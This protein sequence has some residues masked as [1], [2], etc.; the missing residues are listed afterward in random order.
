[1]VIDLLLIYQKKNEIVER[2]K[3]E[4]IE[5]IEFSVK[6]EDLNIIH[7]LFN[8]LGFIKVGHHKTKNIIFF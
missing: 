3:I 1:M 5:F 4:K 6:K 2:A 8:S 7:A